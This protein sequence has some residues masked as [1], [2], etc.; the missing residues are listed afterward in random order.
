MTREEIYKL[1]GITIPVNLEQIRDAYQERFNEGKDLTGADVQ[2]L[3]CFLSDLVKQSKV[4]IL[5]SGSYIR[6]RSGGGS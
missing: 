3:K 1:I 5:A 2:H 4:V 6:A